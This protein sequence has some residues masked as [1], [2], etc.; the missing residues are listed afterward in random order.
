MCPELDTASQGDSIEG[1]R[2][3]LSEAVELFFECASASE[4]AERLHSEIY[5]TPF[6]VHVG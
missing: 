6:E 4:I 1:A 5:V 2:K 3:N